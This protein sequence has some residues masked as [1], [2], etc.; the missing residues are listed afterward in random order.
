MKRSC[1]WCIP[2]LLTLLL[3]MPSASAGGV[4]EIDAFEVV[5]EIN[6]TD[7]DAGFQGSIDGGIAWVRMTVWNTEYREI[8]RVRATREL[9]RQGLSEYT[10]ESNEPQF[11]TPGF[12]LDSFLERFPEGTYRAWGRALGG[13][14]LYGE[15]ELT[16]SLPA[17]PV[18][19]SPE[20]Y[21]PGE[22]YEIAWDA[23]VEDFR[24]GALG[25]EI[26]HYLVVAE[27]S[28]EVDGEEVSRSLEFEVAGDVLQASIPGVLFPDP[29]D[30][31]EET[32]EMKVEIG[33]VEQSGNRTFTEKELEAM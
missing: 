26:A 22:D 20:G 13:G 9:G 19:T 12:E 6:A 23:V 3:G 17:G 2:L 10:W 27:Y 5:V 14:W 15:A 8:Q 33:A 29:D 4:E 7:G 25:S 11:E 21:A 18:I 16:H 28:G 1:L 32:F 31:D 24:G 30:F